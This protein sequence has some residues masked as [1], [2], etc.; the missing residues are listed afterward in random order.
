ML[1]PNSRKAFLLTA[2]RVL[3]GFR[4]LEQRV[5]GDGLR[6]EHLLELR[7]LLGAVR[8]LGHLLEILIANANTHEANDDP[9][10]YSQADVLVVDDDADTRKALTSALQMA[11]LDVVT[12]NDGVEALVA[13]H[14]LRPSL[15]IMDIAMPGLSGLE[16]ARLLKAAAPTRA[17]PVIAHTGKPEECRAY[18]P[19]LF[20]CIL[21]KPIDPDVLLP[22]VSHFVSSPMPD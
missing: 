16:A 4:Q 1:D 20:A 21:S 8:E 11:D 2:E 6:H 14:N 12:A 5:Q 17:I 9:R 13:A 7:R 18:E 3:D 10:F 22:L 19:A 15:I